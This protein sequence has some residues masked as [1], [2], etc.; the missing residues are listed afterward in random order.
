MRVS[1]L[2]RQPESAGGRHPLVLL[3]VKREGKWEHSVVM[4]RWLHLFVCVDIKVY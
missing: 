3:E 4:R 2:R 1:D